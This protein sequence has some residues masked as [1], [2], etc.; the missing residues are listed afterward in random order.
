MRTI[1]ESGNQL[2][3]I[4]RFVLEGRSLIVG[5]YNSAAEYDQHVASTTGSGGTFGFGE[6]LR[7]DRES[8]ALLSVWVHAPENTEQISESA[9]CET[10]PL[11]VGIPRIPKEFQRLEWPRVL[12][13]D[14]STSFLAALSEPLSGSEYRLSVARDFELILG[15]QL[16]GWVLRSPAKYLS[17]GWD[18]ASPAPDNVGEL[19]TQLAH[20]LSLVNDEFTIKLENHDETALTQLDDLLASVQHLSTSSQR[21]ALE[22]AIK[23][24][25]ENY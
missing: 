8:E 11:R 22:A 2:Q 16:T 24:V 3:W 13:F 10:A 5:P 9:V 15:N 25:R 14:A 12:V 4:P 19:G 18:A 1:I 23:A 7:F 20:F 6:A 21:V 17:S